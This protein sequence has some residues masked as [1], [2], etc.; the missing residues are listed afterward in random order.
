MS[1]Q[2]GI[3][4][5]F[6]SGRQAAASIRDE[7]AEWQAIQSGF[8]RLSKYLEPFTK[9][10]LSNSGGLQQLAA[11]L[12][13]LPANPVIGQ[14]LQELRDQATELAASIA[15]SRVE[16][17]GR[18]EA[19]YIRSVRGSERAVREL[20]S[21]WRV[22]I[23][24]LAV[25]RDQGLIR[26]LYNHEPLTDWQPVANVT[27]VAE[28]ERKAFTLLTSAAMREEDLIDSFWAAYQ[29]SLARRGS[30][31]SGSEVHVSDFYIELR[32][33]RMRRE[34][35]DG[36]PDRKLRQTELPRWAFLYNVDL[37]RSLRAAV[38][39]DR[40]L[41]FQTG[42]MAESKTGIT[43]NGFDPNQDY[44]RVVYVVHAQG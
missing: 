40:R 26:F 22:G 30:N 25:Q 36:K 2:A 7:Q 33:E 18:I 14:M 38:P 13:K 19:E 8:K 20:S 32:L 27:E 15:R 31:R 34:L 16:A 37:Y 21:G 17:F 9:L 6:I 29:A 42:A 12:E 35:R 11:A 41:G 44:R 3:F 39:A 1:M 28:A 10:K 23:L 4:E 43:I 24:E 5:D